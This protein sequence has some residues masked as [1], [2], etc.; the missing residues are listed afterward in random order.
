MNNARRTF[1]FSILCVLLIGCNQS[2]DAQPLPLDLSFEE[3]FQLQLIE[4]EPGTIIDV[5]AGTHS[6]TRS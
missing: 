5:P 3:S 1:F 4:A 6:F 2:E